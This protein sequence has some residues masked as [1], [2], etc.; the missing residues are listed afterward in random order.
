LWVKVSVKVKDLDLPIG[1]FPVYARAES[2]NRFSQIYI[3]A[4]QRMFT[5]DFWQN[6]VALG[7]SYTDSLIDL[8]RV[9]HEWIETEISITELSKKFMFVTADEKAEY[10]EQEREVEWKWQECQKYIPE[11]F[12]ELVPFLNEASQNPKLRRLFPF[13]SM[14][15]FHFS[16]CTGY[17]YSGDC[18]VVVPLEN[19]RYKVLDSKGEFI[20]EGNATEAVELVV[21]H[22]PFNS[23]TAVKGT[24]KDLE[25]AVFKRT[26]A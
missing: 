26:D 4:E 7:N 11:N 14:N 16:R 25:A 15:T 24:A 18:P 6:G 8:A 9:L 21:S 2:N 20:G 5:C 22:L 3:S 12:P 17:P 1:G 13:T 10:F 23:G 19:N